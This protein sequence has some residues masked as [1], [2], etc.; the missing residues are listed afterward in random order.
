[1]NAIDL[2][3]LIFILFFFVRGLFRGFVLE[4]ITLIG[5][6]AGYLI[7]IS[8]MAPI[9]SLIINYIPDLPKSAIDIF[10]F[11][12]LFV[13]TNIVLKVIAN[14]ITKTLK[15]AMLGW[16]NR[17]LGGSFGILKSVIILSIAVLLINLIP[18]SSSLLQ[19]QIIRESQLYP[20]L[21]MLG[22][23]LYKQINSLSAIL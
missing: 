20:L 3:I 2:V 19:A 14:M 4:L 22:P 7:A 18:F 5:I 6:V 1:M 11:A 13:A 8:Y 21:D 17:W 23:E 10:S 9:T 16:L 15:F 12:L